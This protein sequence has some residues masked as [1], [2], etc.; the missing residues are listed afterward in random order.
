M[1]KRV[2]SMFMVLAMLICVLPV[3]ADAATVMQKIAGYRAGEAD[4]DGAVAEIVSYNPRNKSFYVVNGNEQEVHIVSLEALTTGQETTLKDAKVIDIGAITKE[5]LG[6]ENMDMTSIAVGGEDVV[7][8]ALQS[9]EYTE[10]GA[11]I[12][13]D[14]GGNY[15]K[16]FEAGVQP[17]MVTFSQDKAYVFTANEG[18]PREGYGENT[19]DPKGSV[20]IVNLGDGTVNT[21][22]FTAF[23]DK[24]AELVEKGVILKKDAAVSEDLE[25][26][27]IAAAQD[28]SFAYVSLQENNAIATIDYAKGEVLSI[29][30]LGFKDHSK[31]ENAIDVNRDDQIIIKTEP[32]YGIN[33]PDAVA[34]YTVGGKNY[35]VTANEGDGREWGEGDNEY[36]NEVDLGGYKKDIVVI[37]TEDYE[38]GNFE[39]GKNY[40][41]GARSFS[42]YEAETMKQVYDSGSDF[43]R[44]TG[45][46]LPDYFNISNDNL[47]LDH[48]SSK[49]GP[50][51]EGVITGEI[52]DRIYAFIGLERIGGVMMYDVTDPSAPIYIEYL[53]TR[54][55]T[56]DIA[57]DVAPE[58]LDFISEEQS[59]TGKP[60]VLV[61]NEVSGTVSV[62]EISGASIPKS[63][64]TVERIAGQNR[65]ETANSVEDAM[66]QGSSTVILV[67]GTKEAD[68]LTAGVLAHQL[69][70][71]I[72]LTNEGGLPTETAAKLKSE[73]TKEI[74]LIGG[75]ASISE[76]QEAEL[77]T[78]GYTVSRIAGE[79]RYETAI[80]VAKTVNGKAKAE[81][82]LLVNGEHFPDALAAGSYAAVNGTPILLTKA[83]EMNAATKAFIE[84]EKI[85]KVTI[86]GGKA[87]VSEGIETGLGD[88]V[89]RIAGE[90]RYET[91]T[92]L[93]AVSFPEAKNAIAA[94]GTE[95]IDS[96]VAGPYAAK[97]QAP[98]LLV[99]TGKVPTVVLDY[100]NG[101]DIENVSIIG[102]AK[103]VSNRVELELR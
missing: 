93:A 16:H 69:G 100:L 95:L 39:T 60:L 65:F 41:F 49:K 75:V 10:N 81:N 66:D 91:A 38:E 28:G 27:Y 47:T 44:I 11:I 76:A 94:S 54:E 53:N 97:L 35:V 48:R 3:Q 51:P 88:K 15:V 5:H 14:D 52:G 73:D 86:I 102:G 82:A 8:I 71:P 74:R 83:D 42:I 57:G 63:F 90:N 2:I 29:D 79:N 103:S 43:E 20:T 36:L 21:L 56:D 9:A 46:L 98:I 24:R 7:A 96:L 31:E 61:A 12:L 30:G 89:E 70:A 58:G 18:E 84:A 55:F 1:K 78:A 99:E 23:D 33:M 22:D 59:P 85:E 4:E 67:N 40:L 92:K 87:S 50:E 17:D 13:L 101:S 45:A 26:E 72:L 68:A 25:P 37:A 6:Q 32:L 77:K 64:R 80:E 34:T 19:T 62:L